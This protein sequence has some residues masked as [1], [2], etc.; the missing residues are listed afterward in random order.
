[1]PMRCGGV[2]SGDGP[3]P[4]VVGTSTTIVA[5]GSLA[6]LPTPKNSWSYF[7]GLWKG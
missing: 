7:P 5:S 4:P 3:V 6:Y 2:G 1:M